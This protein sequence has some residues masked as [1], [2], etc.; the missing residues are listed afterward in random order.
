MVLFLNKIQKLPQFTSCIPKQG[1]RHEIP[2]PTSRIFSAITFFWSSPS[3]SRKTW[4]AQRWQVSST[5]KSPI[6]TT[7][8]AVLTMGAHLFLSI[9]NVFSR[10]SDFP[11]FFQFPFF[12]R[13][14]QI[15]PIFK[16][17]GVNFPIWQ[18][19][20]ESISHFVNAKLL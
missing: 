5:V 6:S 8:A 15:S 20:A 12:S 10:F 17:S 11:K 2:K 1:C 7:S 16:K 14:I 3:C 19:C 4:V 18:H 9:T 13:S